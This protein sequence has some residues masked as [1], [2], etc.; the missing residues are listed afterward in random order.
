LAARIGAFEASLCYAKITPA[1]LQRGE[2]WDCCRESAEAAGANSKFELDE[3]PRGIAGAATPI[4][5]ALR[6]APS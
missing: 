5:P 2:S 6:M 1:A 3:F 4:P